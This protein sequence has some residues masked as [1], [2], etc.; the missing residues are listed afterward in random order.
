MRENMND[1]FK[2]LEARVIDTLEK[3]DLERIREELIKI[4]GPVICS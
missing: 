3:S 4:K 1:N 2:L